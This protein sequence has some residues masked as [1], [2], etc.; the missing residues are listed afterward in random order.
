MKHAL[1][2]GVVKKLVRGM[3]LV[4]VSIVL[5]IVGIIGALMFAILP[6]L[7][8]SAKARNETELLRTVINSVHKLRSNKPNFAGVDT[9]LVVSSGVVPSAMVNGT[10][11]VNQQAGTITI[12]AATVTTANDA[13]TMTSTNY[14]DALCKELAVNM[15]SAVARIAVNGTEVKAVNAVL[16]DA[17]LFAACTGNAN[18]VA[19]TFTKG[20]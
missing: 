14:S 5:I 11:I 3:T 16:N 9:A 12:A 7:M 8:A 4:E 17:G 19:F 6:S 10:S 13:V 1:K 2:A 18:S 15:E 20:S